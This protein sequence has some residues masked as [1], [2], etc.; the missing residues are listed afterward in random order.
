MTL[1]RRAA[2]LATL[3][4]LA[5]GL[6]S[7]ASCGL[8]FDEFT[9]VDPAQLDG[10][11]ADTPG[12][13]LVDARADS[14]LALDAD[15]PA[16]GPRTLHQRCTRGPD[17]STTCS[18]GHVCLVQSG[19]SLDGICVRSCNDVSDCPAPTSSWRCV[20]VDPSTQ[21]KQCTAVCD[22]LTVGVCGPDGMCKF[23]PQHPQQNPTRCEI[24]GTGLQDAFCYG[25]ELSNDC[26]PGF[27]CGRARYRQCVLM[28]NCEQ[29]CRV[30]M[31]D[32]PDGG[33]C[34]GSSQTIGGVNFGRCR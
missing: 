3:S 30:G 12:G 33:S 34:V 19:Y 24:A 1:R 15:A 21:G 23:E 7:L 32:C 25:G 18:A 27:S 16:P 31:N 10:S 28:G 9:F 13:G 29:L 4:C 14:R 20:S 22:P 11:S 6:G 8:A 26:A 5:T 17:A 2:R